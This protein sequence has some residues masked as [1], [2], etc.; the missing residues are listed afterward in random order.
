MI[1]AFW[2][3]H[4]ALFKVAAHAHQKSDRAEC[5]EKIDDKTELAI[6]GT[7]QQLGKR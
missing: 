2:V 4:F 1:V 5:S 7:R 3:L 6:F